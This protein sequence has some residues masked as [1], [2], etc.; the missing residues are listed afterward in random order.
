MDAYDKVVAN[1]DGL[2]RAKR[3]AAVSH[4]RLSLWFTGLKDN[5]EEIGGLVPLAIRVGAD[6][7]NLQMLFPPG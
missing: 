2:A 3:E 4:P 5:I 6:A 1:L 7:I